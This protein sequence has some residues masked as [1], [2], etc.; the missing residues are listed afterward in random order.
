[1]NKDNSV[2]EVLKCKAINIQGT[3]VVAGFPG[4]GKTYCTN[5][6]FLKGKYKMIDSDSSLFSHI[7]K[8]RT[9]KV[10]PEWPDNYIDYIKSTFGKYNFV[11]V[12]THQIVRDTLRE[13]RIPYILVYPKQTETN[14][15]EYIAK[16]I[17]RDS[18]KKFV[19]FMTDNWENFLG[20]IFI[21]SWPAHYELEEG[22][23]LFDVIDD[24]HFMK[25]AF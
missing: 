25:D 19:E 15:I 24:I 14:K 18:P 11:F 5:N 3:V 16:Y 13:E 8:N 17:K 23:T 10:H 12:S 6:S 4:I 22:E 20:D 1:M 2:E 9:K 21:D 7:E